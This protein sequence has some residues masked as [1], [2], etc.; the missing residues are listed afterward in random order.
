MAF[1]GYLVKIGSYT[2]PNRLLELSG[3]SAKVNT[4][5]DDS[6]RDNY[7]G[8]HRDV[9]AQVPKV[10]LKFKPMSGNDFDT[11]WSAVEAQYDVDDERK[12]DFTMW[13]PEWRRYETQAMYIAD[14]EPTIESINGTS[15]NYAGFSISIISYSE[16]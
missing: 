11:L 2:I 6:F 16:D 8:L 7:G 15:I 9:I 4:L 12:A 5:D 13:V 3:Y 10:T 14:F 1:S